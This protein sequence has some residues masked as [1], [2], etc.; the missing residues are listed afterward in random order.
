[1]L[2]EGC[3]CRHRFDC[4][5][6]CCHTGVLS[7][8]A[9]TLLSATVPCGRLSRMALYT[10]SQESSASA[11]PAYGMVC[12]QSSVMVSGQGPAM[13]A[14]NLYG[15]WQGYGDVCVGDLL[16]HGLEPLHAEL[17]GG[18]DVHDHPPPT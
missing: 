12:S 17:L 2:S 6:C 14:E 11:A 10:A 5:Q 8:R 15:Q 7:L 18:A 3:C 9:P 4:G 1:M 16:L 13:R